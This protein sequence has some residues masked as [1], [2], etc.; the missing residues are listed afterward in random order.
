M[1]R[2]LEEKPIGGNN[3]FNVEQEYMMN[4]LDQNQQHYLEQYRKQLRRDLDEMGYGQ[5]AQ[6]VA[7]VE[8]DSSRAT[9]FVMAFATAAVLFLSLSLSRLIA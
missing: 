8:S 9:G 3:R 7:L 6:P 4:S 1:A 2:C 5:R